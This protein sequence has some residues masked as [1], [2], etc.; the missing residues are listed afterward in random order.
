MPLGAVRPVLTE[1]VRSTEVLPGANATVA[2][3]SALATVPPCAEVMFAGG[4]DRPL[5]VF[6]VGSGAVV[7]VA[8][9]S[10]IVGA[11]ATETVPAPV[12]LAQPPVPVAPPV[13]AVTT[14]VLVV[15]PEPAH[16]FETGA[17][18]AVPLTTAVSADASPVPLDVEIVPE[19]PVD[20]VTVD[21]VL[22]LVSV[23]VPASPVCAV[24]STGA[25]GPVGA[26]GAATAGALVEVTVAVVA[27][28]VG[29]VI[30]VVVEESAGDVVGAV[31]VVVGAVAVVVG[32][33]VVVVSVVVVSV[34]VVVA[35]VAEL[36]VESGSETLNGVKAPAAAGSA[37]CI[38][39][40]A[41]GSAASG[42]GSVACAVDGAAS[43]GVL[44]SGDCATLGAA[45]ELGSA[46]GVPMSSET[47]ATVANGSAAAAASC[48]ARVATC[49]CLSLITGTVRRTIFRVACCV[50]A[51]L[52]VCA[53]GDAAGI[54]ASLWIFGTCRS[55]M[56]K[57]GN[58]TFGR[59]RGCTGY[60]GWRKTA[61]TGAAYMTM[62]TSTP[63]PAHQ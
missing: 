12:L 44:V 41:S 3:P 62:S 29:E 34:V 24:T 13:P 2:F 26:S 60:V 58:A 37:D 50:G 38:A 4:G 48:F 40:A 20:A 15:L 8:P 55:G 17:T 16:T 56:P 14:T 32:A 47:A 61:A 22:T 43:A 51:A 49:A 45:A 7:D 19:T 57:L 23:A 28:A 59:V 39:A 10:E 42:S 33:V 5:A 18:V 30:V 53:T 25:D 21:V 54:G 36:A 6:A 11:G 31:A 1:T 27:G 46:I 52:C 9:V 63:A 35:V